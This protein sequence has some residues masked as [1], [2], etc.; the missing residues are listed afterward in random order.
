MT[1][2]INTGAYLQIVAHMDDDLLFMNPDLQETINAGLPIT[3]LYLTAGEAGTV[4]DP[5]HPGGPGTVLP[6]QIG[7]RPQPVGSDAPS[8]FAI[9]RAD[10]AGC[11]Q[12]GSRA[13]WAQMCGVPN[14]WIRK[15]ITITNGS[16]SREVEVNTLS[17]T[18]APVTLIFV[19]LPDWADNNADIKPHCT[20]NASG[21]MTCSNPADYNTGSSL[22]YI[23]QN[24]SVRNTILVTDGMVAQPQSYALSDLIELITQVVG[25]YDITVLRVQDPEPDSR[26]EQ[27]NNDKGWE[28]DHLDHIMG[29]RIVAQAIAGMSRLQVVN[30]RNYNVQ[31]SPVNLDTTQQNQKTA[32]FDL[33]ASWDAYVGAD[34]QYDHWPLREYHRFWTGDNWV[35][36]NANGS[37]LVF[38]VQDGQ[39]LMWTQTGLGTFTGP[40]SMGSPGPLAPGL[41][42]GNNQDGRVEVFA[43]RLD[44]WHTVTI[45]QTAVNGAPTQWAWADLGNPN[46]SVGDPTQVGLPCL[47]MNQDGRMQIFAKNGGGGISTT[48]QTAANSGW[49]PQWT[50]LGQGPGIQDGL[51]AKL[52]PAGLIEL[53]ALNIVNGVA[54]ILNMYQPQPNGGFNTAPSFATLAPASPPTIAMNA[55]GR[56]DIFYRLADG[57]DGPSGGNVGHTWQTAVAGGYTTTPQDIGGNGGVGPVSVVSAPT[58]ISDARIILLQRDRTGQVSMNAQV[59]PNEGYGGSWTS[60]GGFTANEPTLAADA[61]GVMYAFA[62]DGQGK[63]LVAQQTSAAGGAPFGA[64]TRQGT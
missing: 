33:Y 14:N 17:G 26:Y 16:W 57:A 34:D 3:S 27:Q 15:A 35:G 5:Q 49:T 38:D 46:S 56:F 19:N 32:T 31:D 54:S 6:T 23:L 45:Y 20:T 18:T 28:G 47:A 50:D 63:L 43:L 37:L 22:Q 61:T 40:V 60:F 8:T 42:V 24:S 10:Y 53:F 55:D 2:P 36:R 4:P 59:G 12:E 39:L 11:R 41:A 58:N 7:C 44:N 1:T 51:A 21:V 64:W 52:N 30:Y 48:Y 25:M 13:A 9:A 29:A 62:F